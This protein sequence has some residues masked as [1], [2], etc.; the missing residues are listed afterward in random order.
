MSQ[1]IMTIKIFCLKTCNSYRKTMNK[2]DF[3]RNYSKSSLKRFVNI[4]FVLTNL[5]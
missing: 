3:L 5:F 2:C 4:K 1:I